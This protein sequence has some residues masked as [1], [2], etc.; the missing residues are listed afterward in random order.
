[1]ITNIQPHLLPKILIMS[2]LIVDRKNLKQCGPGN[3]TH[4]FYDD[5]T[6]FLQ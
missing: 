5:K 3:I 6:Y 1:M 4:L 2:F